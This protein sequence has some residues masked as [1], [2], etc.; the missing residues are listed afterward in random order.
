MHPLAPKFLL[1][2]L[3]ML[4]YLLALSPAILVSGVKGVVLP[5]IE[6]MLAPVHGLLQEIRQQ[7]RT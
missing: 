3:R 7:Q 4:A 1:P 2:C 6:Q 5:G